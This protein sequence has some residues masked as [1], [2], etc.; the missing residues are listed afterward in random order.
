M[1]MLLSF[2][3]PFSIIPLLKFSNSIKK[4]GP[5]KESIYVRMQT[6]CLW[7]KIIDSVHFHAEPVTDNG[8]CHDRC[9]QTVV[10][11]WTISLTIIIMNAYFIVWAYMDW[12]IHNHLS[13]YANAIISIVFFAL[14]GAYIT[15]ILYLMLRKDKV[16]TYTSALERAEADSSIILAPVA[17]GD[18][19]TPFRED[20]AEASM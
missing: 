16:V 7:F 4:I 13:K 14:M 15:A 3:L 2:E 18:Q 12:L 20:L 5:L 8:G 9:V 19:P 1:Q 6:D 11:A 17:D 10:L